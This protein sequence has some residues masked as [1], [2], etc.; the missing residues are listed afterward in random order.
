MDHGAT[1]RRRS[2]I[3]LPDQ[4][5]SLEKS[6]SVCAFAELRSCFFGVFLIVVV[7]LHP[8][9]ELSLLNLTTDCVLEAYKHHLGKGEITNICQIINFSE[10]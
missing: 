6:L 5:G 9:V 1:R 2:F 8:F 4:L 7:E 10:T 3:P